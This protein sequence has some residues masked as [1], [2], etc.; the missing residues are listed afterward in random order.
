MQMRL[1]PE[2]K[3]PEVRFQA[4][5][6]FIKKGSF[7]GI[8]L[9]FTTILALILSNSPAA[10]YYQHFRHIPLEIRIGNLHLAKPLYHWVNDGLM[11][12]FFLLIGLEVKREILEG[13]LASIRQAVL[14][15][16]AA[17]VG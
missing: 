7:S 15:G 1:I 5:E 6:D 9:I 11:A 10:P 16:V 4:L 12:I 2:V 8:L 3:L 17:L 13:H 14:P